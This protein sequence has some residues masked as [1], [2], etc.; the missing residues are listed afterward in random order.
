MFDWLGQKQSAP[1]GALIRQIEGDGWQ[2]EL[3]LTPQRLALEIPEERTWP[4]A[5]EELA[6][7]CNALLMQHASGFSMVSVSML[8]LKAKLFDDSLYAA[9][10]LAIQPR[11]ASLVAGLGR[12]SPLL[13]AAAK[14][15]GLDAQT[16]SAAQE[17]AREF[18]SDPVKS[19]PLGF[20]TWSEDLRRIFQQDRLLQERLEPADLEA[21]TAALD[22]DPPAKAVYQDYLGF[23]A[24]LTNPLATD[25]PPLF[26]ADAAYF[27]PPSRSCEGDLMT[28]LFGDR[29]IPDG[30]SLVDEVMRRVRN[31]SLTLEPSPNSGWY[32]FQ[33]WALEALIIPD[34]M[35]EGARLTMNDRY[36]A[37][38]EDVVKA[39]IS[40]ARETH[41]KRVEVPKLGARLSHLEPVAVRVAPELTVE[42]IRSYYQRR[43]ES[44]EFV[45]R[46]LE[47]NT[48]FSSMHAMTPT[49]PS[50]QLLSE[51]LEAVTA[52]FRGAAA[53]AGHELGIEPA[54]GPDVARFREWAKSPDI[55]GDVRMMVPIFHDVGR[56][57]TK[58]WAIL[59]WAT[60]SLRVSYVTPP[61]VRVTKGS[62]HVKW[63]P[64]FR[65]IAYPVFAETYVSRLLDR[66]EF[67]AHCDRYK[68]A[69]RILEHL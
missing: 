16:S 18:L 43:A 37:Q 65:Q 26:N 8:A 20:Y 15:G 5:R 28:H 47:V 11:K 66:D 62:P 3:D 33:S 23:V 13:A 44:Y 61:S 50:S 35:P 55:G 32:G 51:D 22:A 19:K 54:K 48:S 12:A 4:E 10:E 68:T 38:L 39:I 56:K 64:T 42:P 29:P 63:L 21:L 6:P 40:L 53:V 30:F 14:L 34:R 52:L 1:S 45:R 17:I 25:K 27:F 67:R 41:V 46:L 59:G 31:G 24:R 36:R 58:V 7:T 49:G 9:V 57:K 69:E 2:I 60:R